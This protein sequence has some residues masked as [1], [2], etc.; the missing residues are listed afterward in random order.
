MASTLRLGTTS[1]S[2]KRPNG[3]V[4]S[5]KV[6][7]LG[8]SGTGK[9]SII[10]QFVHRT[11]DQSYQAT[12]GMDFV[13]KML[14]AE[15]CQR[16][17]RLQLW[18]TAGQERF[19]ALIPGY[20]RDS[21]ACV[22]VY[23]VTSRESFAGVRSWVEQATEDRPGK[24]FVLALVGNKVDLEPQRAVTYREGEVLAR[25]LSM[26]FFEASAR[27]SELVDAVFEGIAAALPSEV[28][29]KTESDDEIVLMA[30]R[31]QQVSETRKK[32]CCQH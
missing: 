8:Q 3:P 26:L 2:K 17:V 1:C 28:P 20:L 5:H 11:F 18:D 7:F 15:G 24:D 30:P 12:V 25:E 32:Q 13:S 9:T 23:D 10:Q 19:R 16:P 4:R 29:M 31:R 27:T 22:V 14:N 21:A 6:V